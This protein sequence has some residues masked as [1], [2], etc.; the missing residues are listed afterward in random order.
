MS[1][2][3]E[4]GKTL[5]Q[6]VL[7]KLPE[8]L[9][10]EAEKA[11]SAPEATDALTLLGDS[12]LARGDYSRKMDE[13]RDLETKAQEQLA[14]NQTDYEALQKWYGE[15]KAVIDKYPTLDAVD[16]ELARRAG[17][18]TLTSREETSPAAGLTKEALEQ[19]L[20]ERDQAR[21]QGY[22]N[23]LGVTTTLT[24][25]HLRDFN[26][27]LDMNDLI[28]HATKHRMPLFDPRAEMDAYRA[29]HGEKIAAKRKADDDAALEKRVQE[30]LA[31]VRKQEGA[32]PYPLRNREP[33]VLDVLSQPDFKTTDYN[34]DA[35]VAE[36]ERLQ[37][38]S[39]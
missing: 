16:A 37:N 34:V 22:A 7:A 24:A 6:A 30:R 33:S 27:V 19:Y 10:A 12:A 20:A 23:V 29:V 32:N 8:N 31:E 4:S 28:A 9:R 1:K 5:L 39:H 18:P 14:A 3:L 26:E 17:Q 38:G 13:I 15:K 2:A 35:A 25:R 36:Y 21:D 11:L